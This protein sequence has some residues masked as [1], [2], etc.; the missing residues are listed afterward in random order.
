MND[1][2]VKGVVA[3]LAIVVVV[4]ILVFIFALSGLNNKINNRTE[5]SPSP[6]PT[7][8]NGPVTNPDDIPT[9]GPQSWTKWKVL[10]GP[11][12]Y[13]YCLGDK[14][15]IVSEGGHVV[16]RDYE[17]DEQECGRTPVPDPFESPAVVN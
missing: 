1:K 6:S 10:G 15:Y 11:T 17:S 5:Q 12:I 8:S 14:A 13:R 9:A 7:D 3:G 4:M 2:N 16:Y